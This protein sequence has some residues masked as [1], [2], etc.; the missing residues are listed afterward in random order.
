MNVKN[1]L[2]FILGLIVGAG[3][4]FGYYH[5]HKIKNLF[6]SQEDLMQAS[7]S[8]PWQGSLQVNGNNI[9]FSLAIKKSGDA[10]SGVITA[11]QVGNI[12]CDQIA[13]DA[14]GNVS[15]TAHVND[16]NATFTG[17]VASDT[18][19]MTGSFTSNALGTGGWSLA[20]P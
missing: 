12:P 14:S 9:G 13:V 18:H 3:L 8:G 7:V 15:F 2:S 4:L 1:S 5:A 16:K 6:R 10:L 20:K 19:S 17:K 11:P